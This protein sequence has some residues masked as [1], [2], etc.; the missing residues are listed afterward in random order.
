MEV[1]VSRKTILRCLLAG[2][3]MGTV[4]T[5]WG[6]DAEDGLA[7]SKRHPL[8]GGDYHPFAANSPFN[9][10]I[11]ASPKLDPHSTQIISTLL[12][13]TNNS[14]G[15]IRAA[16]SPKNIDYTFPFYYSLP[17]DPVFTVKC[18]YNGPPPKWGRCPLQNAQIH[19]PSYALPENSGGAPLSSDHHL[20]IIDPQTNT[21]YDMWAS[22][23]PEPGGGTLRIGWGGTGPT[24]GPGIN[25]FGAT[26]SGFALTIGIVRAAD[27]KA[28]VIPHALQMAIPCAADGVYPAAVPSDL[29]CAAGA[30]APY[31]GM[32]MQLDMT[33]T[34]IQALNAPSYVK[35]LY[36][37]LAHYGAFVSDT[38]TGD[39]IGF[40]TEGGL[41]YTQLGMADPWVALAQANGLTPDPPQPDPLAAYRFALDV[42][43]VDL[44]KRLRVIAPCVTAGTC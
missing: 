17:T 36:T 10:P 39:S 41:T 19:I 24:T 23:K 1:L 38:G 33:D 22:A 3:L 29:Q 34:E 43:G 11:P 25:V 44:S 15:I 28:G 7:A 42:A 32:R 21:E 26:A 12:G 13:M 40:Q 14:L 31:Y 9:V 30:I 18:F 2:I 35:T 37:A 6:Q 5:C 16:A 27:M 8:P 4:S 20:A